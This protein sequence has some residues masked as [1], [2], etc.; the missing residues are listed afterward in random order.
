MGARANQTLQPYS[1]QKNKLFSSTGK[2]C[3][4][5]SRRR[6]TLSTICT[7]LLRQQIESSLEMRRFSH[8]SDSISPHPA[9]YIFLKGCSF[10]HLL[11]VTMKQSYSTIVANNRLCDTLYQMD[12]K[13][14]NDTPAPLPGQFLTARISD[15]VAPL[16]RRPFAYSAFD[17]ATNHASIIYQVRGAGTTQLSSYAHGTPVDIIGPLGNH[18]SLPPKGTKALLVAGGIGLGPILF[19]ASHLQAENIEF[20]LVFGCKTA[21]L[22]PASALDSF[23]A[24]ICSDDGSCGFH[25]S[26]IDYLDSIPLP[27]ETTIY[28][29]GPHPM[30]HACHMFAVKNGLSCYVSVE[31]TMACGV[32]ACMGCAIKINGP[33]P[34][35]RACKEGPVF[36]SKDI[37]WE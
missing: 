24:T 26:V 29:C 22:L 10:F 5:S 2:R 23:S 4:N 36:N 34:Y 11:K 20:N 27:A 19:F 12:I 17:T 6:A 8:K 1:C 28:S 30:L 7:I 25:G 3:E 33:T 35:A 18:F 37:A 9:Q 16:L 13:F 21:A 31:Q 14:S 32:G 15:T